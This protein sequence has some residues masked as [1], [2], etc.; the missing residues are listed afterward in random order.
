MG[1]SSVYEMVVNV[2]DVLIFYVPNTFTPDGDDVNNVFLPVF[3][4]GY[5]IY[6]YHF[7]VFNRWGEVM[8]ESYNSA[9][10]WEGTYGTQGLVED[11]V[12]VWR[13]EFGDNRSDKRHKHHGH[14]TVLK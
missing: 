13:I 11:G 9:V 14:V 2:Q 10:G 8:F 7:T 4:S 12:Y 3:T 6:D 5:D 1:C